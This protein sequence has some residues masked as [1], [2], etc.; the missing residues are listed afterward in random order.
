L[1]WIESGIA[2]VNYTCAFSAEKHKAGEAQRQPE[3][4][5]APVALFASDEAPHMTGGSYL[6][7]GG[8]SAT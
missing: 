7:D 8:R 4:V 1:R 3:E 2:K 5:A 6:I